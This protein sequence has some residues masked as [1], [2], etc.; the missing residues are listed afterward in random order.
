VRC[1]PT[2]IL[3]VAAAL[4]AAAAQAQTVGRPHPPAT[5][6]VNQLEIGFSVVDL[7]HDGRVTREEARSQLHRRMA[8][9]DFNRDGAIDQT[10]L[11]A[12][13]TTPLGQ[14]PHPPRRPV[15]PALSGQLQAL[16][17]LVDRDRDGRVSRGEA[18]SFLDARFPLVDRDGDGAV[19]RQ[20][21][22]AALS[23]P[24]ALIAS[25]SMPQFWR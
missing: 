13:A 7:N 17:W 11:T 15:P 24:A 23:S 12:L 14:K 18:Q 19:T 3:I 6:S 4:L 21:A 22:R 1:T 16:F 20:E 8:E 10:E 25:L 2:I 9:A 5:A